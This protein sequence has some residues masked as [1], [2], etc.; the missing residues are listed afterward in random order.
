MQDD[1]IFPYAFQTLSEADMLLAH[2]PLPQQIRQMSMSGSDLQ[3]KHSESELT[4]A[5]EELTEVPLPPAEPCELEEGLQRE[6][7]TTVVPLPP[8]EPHELEEEGLHRS[9][10]TTVQQEQPQEQMQHE[11]IQ[12]EQ[13]KQKQMQQ[14]I[15]TPPQQH[16][17]RRRNIN[18]QR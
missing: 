1:R 13:T 9:G 10:D 8:T 5:I 18:Q 4:T 6:G 16:V 15:Q 11:Q 17:S 14:E 3:A 7:D 2:T 12:Q